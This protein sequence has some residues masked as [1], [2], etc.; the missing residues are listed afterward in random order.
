MKCGGPDMAAWGREVY[1]GF[2]GFHPINLIKEYDM[3][4]RNSAILLSAAVI[5]EFAMAAENPA[6]TPIHA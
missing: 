6:I 2:C 5:G 3:N 1:H 4:T